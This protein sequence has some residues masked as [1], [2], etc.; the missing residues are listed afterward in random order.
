MSYLVLCTDDPYFA[1]LMPYLFHEHRVQ[2]IP[3]NQLKESLSNPSTSSHYIL[4][5]PRLTERDWE[6]TRLVV[7]STSVPV[8]IMVQCEVTEAEAQRSRSLGVKGILL[9]PL[10]KLHNERETV[11]HLLEA[12]LCP[13]R[14][15]KPLDEEVIFLGK[16][17][18]FNLNQHFVYR[19]GDRT[20]LSDREAELLKLFLR[21][22][23]KILT[24]EIIAMELWQGRVVSGGIPK[25]VARLRSKLG[26]AGD[27]IRGRK[28]GGYIYEKNQIL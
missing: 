22:E 5:L 25:L 17:T 3:T 4:G 14:E 23:G 13:I 12:L 18:F 27:L 2:L 6:M 24:K 8:F 1:K 10:L 15:D 26:S 7:N 9:D 19:L 11:N 20:Q 21:Y 28:Q 16:T